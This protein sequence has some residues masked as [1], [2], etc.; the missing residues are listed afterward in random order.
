MKYC[1]ILL[2]IKLARYSNIEVV[3][4]ATGTEAIAVD[5]PRHQRSRDRDVSMADSSL[6]PQCLCKILAPFFL[7]LAKR[8]GDT[9]GWSQ[10]G[11]MLVSGTLPACLVTRQPN[12]RTYLSFQFRVVES[13]CNSLAVSVNRPGKPVFRFLHEP[14]CSAKK[15]QQNSFYATV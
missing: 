4:K 6:I 1:M 10:Q 13:I 11:R 9:L 14:F 15:Q 12:N 2:F 8:T 5:L 7:V 3:S